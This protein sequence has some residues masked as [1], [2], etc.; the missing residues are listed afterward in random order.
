MKRLLLL[1]TL[2]V[3]FTACGN[4]SKGDPNSP[5][6]QYISLSCEWMELSHRLDN[7]NLRSSQEESIRDQMEKLEG[8]MEG[9]QNRHWDYKLTDADRQMLM[10]FL[11]NDLPKYGRHASKKDYRIVESAVTLAD[12]E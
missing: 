4:S 11:D 2:A 3:A 12:L 8:R 10:N 1:L 5:V 7:P 9:L 6:A